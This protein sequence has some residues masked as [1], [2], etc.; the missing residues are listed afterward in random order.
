MKRSEKAIR[1]WFA[2]GIVALCFATKATTV[3]PPT[4]EEM[5]DR[6][7]LIF[8]GKVVGMRAEWRTIGANRVILTLV[9]FERQEVLKGEAGPSITLQFLGG[10][11]DDVTLEVDEVPAFKAGDRELLFVTGNGVQF[12]PLV[13]AFHGK[14]G[15]RKEQKSGRE[16]LVRHN[17]KELRDVTEIGTA[18]GSEFASKRAK[19][20]ISAK[21]E[22]LSLDEFKGKIHDRVANGARRK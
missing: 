12:C 4:F 5:T 20:A 9:E 19:V 8:V 11:V 10:T 15:V 1:L 16:I 3:I 2:I 6:A 7:E 14:F 18:A 22:P 21:T 13:G 17:G